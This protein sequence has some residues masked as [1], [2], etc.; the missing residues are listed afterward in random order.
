MKKIIFLTLLTVLSISVYCQNLDTVLIR[1]G[2]TFTAERWA[3]LIGNFGDI[4]PDSATATEARRIRL[5]IKTANPASWSTNVT[6]DSIKGTFA[7]SFYRMIKTANAGEI[8]THYAAITSAI[9]GVS[10]MSTFISNY[11]SFLLAD[12]NRKRDRGKSIV[13]DN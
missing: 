11:N 7:M 1:P 12:Y 13:M 6:V 4:Y 5:E 8:A 10:I 2:L 9:E 3:W